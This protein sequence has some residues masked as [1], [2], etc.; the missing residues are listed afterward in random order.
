MSKK[1]L[2]TFLTI[3]ALLGYIFNLDRY[4]TNKF[5]ATSNDVKLTYTKYLTIIKD[6]VLRY[7]DQT[8]TIENL[9]D[10]IHKERHFEILFDATKE[11]FHEVQEEILNKKVILDTRYTKVVSYVK[12]ND[13]SKVILNKKV[14]KNTLSAL[15]T[16]SGYSAGI[17]MNKNDQTNAYLNPNEKCNYA[18][19][20]GEQR[21]PGITSGVDKN[22]DMII[23][24]IPKWHDIKEEDVVV[25]SGMDDIF[26]YGI[27]VGFVI[28]IKELVNTK[29]AIIKPYSNVLSRKYFYIIENKS[30]DLN[31]TDINSTKNSSK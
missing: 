22:G 12:L 25:T 17:V 29:M 9:Q 21:A 11:Q 7:Y 4:I 3:L 14:P 13:F 1:V 5:F 8:Q 19:F 27:K 15:V 23:E 20:I 2:F 18:V 10:R 26:P 16:P 24:H 30:I 28:S 31:T 6:T